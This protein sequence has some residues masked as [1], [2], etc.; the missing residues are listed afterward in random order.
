MKKKIFY[1]ISNKRWLGVFNSKGKMGLTL[2]KK[3]YL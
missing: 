1:G 2:K 3:I